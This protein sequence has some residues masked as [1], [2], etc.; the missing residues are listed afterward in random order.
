MNF[1][2]YSAPGEILRSGMCPATMLSIQAGAGEMVM[3]GEGNDREHWVETLTWPGLAPFPFIVAKEPLPA[4]VDKTTLAAN[5]IEAVTISNLPA[6]ARVQVDQAVYE[7]TDGIF[8]F[9]IALPGTYKVR[10]ES[11]PYLPKEWEITAI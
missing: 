3:E 11:F 6:P 10:A 4:T 5:G 8:E 2:V 1:I 7:V 9:T